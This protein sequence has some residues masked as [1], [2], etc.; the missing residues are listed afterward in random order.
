MIENHSHNKPTERVE[1]RHI[2]VKLTG[3]VQGVGLRQAIMH[4]AHDLHLMGFVK[5][6]S[7][8]TTVYFEAQGRKEYLEELVNWCRNSPAWSSVEKFE[9]AELPQTELPIFYIAE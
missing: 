7:D 4:K 5:N 8:K 2:A 1:E 3:L 9:V 6:E